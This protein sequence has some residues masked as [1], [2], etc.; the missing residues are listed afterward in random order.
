MIKSSQNLFYKP[1]WYPYSINPIDYFPWSWL[2]LPKASPCEEVKLEIAQ[3]EEQLN[4]VESYD[5]WKVLSERL[6]VLKGNDAW[7]ED[8]NS[9]FYDSQ[10]IRERLDQLN[11]AMKDGNHER[12]SNILRTG[13]LRNLGGLGNACLYSRVHIGTKKL[14]E[15]Y[16]DAVEASI[17]IVLHDEAL[18]VKK[19]FEF[20]WE[21]RQS[22]GRSALLLSGGA[23][24]GLYHIGVVKTLFEHG[25]LPRII[26]GSSVGSIIASII[27]TRSDDELKE[28]F[29]ADN[30]GVS[31]NAF[32]PNGSFHRK[33]NRLFTK[34]VLM[35]IAKLQNVIRENVGDLTFKEAFK[36]TNRILNIT[37]ASTTEFE[38]PRL[39][40]YLTSPNVV[41]WSAASASCA[42][43]G[44]YEPVELMAK[45]ENGVL[46]PYH[47]SLL[48]WSDGSVAYDLPM[49]R[50]AELF[51]V[52]HFIVSQVNPHVVP[53][54]TG[55]RE[56]YNQSFFSK[57]KQLVFSETNHRIRQLSDL[58]FLPR[59]FNWLMSVLMQTYVGD[60]NIVPNL[61]FSDYLGMLSNPTPELIRSC[62]M[63][64]QRNVWPLLSMIKGHCAISIELEKAVAELREILYHD[65]ENSLKI[66]HGTLRK[67][68]F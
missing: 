34:G 17:Q 51:N 62:T 8:D 7:K 55:T 11:D 57:V 48:K 28:L 46:H 22:F 38:V 41:L 36:K 58:G 3:L 50:L 40:N 39:L 10:L 68:T 52:N 5:E 20:F 67:H 29:S 6:D 64:S 32:D 49:T 33:I 31:L 24:L 12:L 37:V 19:K 42:L 9:G 43:T 65:P 61:S 2:P 23:S 27:S 26:S 25:F 16:I 35:D 13:L 44:L 18:D 53:F 15:N 14:I 63:E 66:F 4:T 59:Q 47:P 21:T 54:V 45:D 56:A 30:M 1:D 60:I